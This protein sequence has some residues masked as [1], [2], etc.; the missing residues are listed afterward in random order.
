M[1]F[2]IQLMKDIKAAFGADNGR[3]Y[4]LT[5]NDVIAE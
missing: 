5:T 1:S 3:V 2:I 4:S